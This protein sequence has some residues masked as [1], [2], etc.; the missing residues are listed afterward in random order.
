V[1][2][3]GNPFDRQQL[4]PSPPGGVNRLARGSGALHVALGL[5]FGAGSVLTIAHLLRTG[6]LPMTPFGFRSMAGGPFDSL[7]TGSFATLGI[8]LSALCAADVLAGAWLW[9]SRRKGLN[10][11]LLTSIPALGLAIGFALPFLIIGVPSRVAL[12]WAAR[13]SLR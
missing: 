1:G 11:A 4:R 13:R 2:D 8:A 10:L 12:A 6:E 7:G 5:G 3:V 9:Q